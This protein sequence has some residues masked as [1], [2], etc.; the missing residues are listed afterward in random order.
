[1]R[2]QA[3]SLLLTIVVSIAAP[4]SLSLYVT[5]GGHV[6]I[7]TFDVCHSTTPA[8][9]TRSSTPYVHEKS[10]CLSPPT[11]AAIAD[12]EIAAVTPISISLPDEHPPK[13]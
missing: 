4:P 7:G 1:M 13:I 10:C 12:I 5:D 3:I 11:L 8:L 2:W 6:M 9:S